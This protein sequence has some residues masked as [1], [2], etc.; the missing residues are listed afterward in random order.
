MLAG[1]A[2]VAADA[3]ADLVDPALLNFLGKKG[4]GNGG[5][6]RPDHVEHAAP[7]LADHGVRRGEPAD[8]NDRL[9]RH[10]LDEGNIGLLLPLLAEAG[11]YRVVFPVAQVDVPQVRELGEHFDDFAPLAVCSDA[12]R[13]HK[14]VNSQAHGDGT[15]VADRVLGLLEQLPKQAKPVFKRP[16]VLVV[17]L[18]AAV[19]KEMHQEGRIVA[20][21]NID[22]VGA[23]LLGA[24][25]R[26]VVPAAELPDI[27]LVHAAGLGRHA[28]DP[29]LR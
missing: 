15:A 3:F 23:G 25:R 10:L 16:A 18:V 17:P 12:L 2:D 26:F 24:Q 13:A 11:G 20:R 4:I 29:R 9:G 28:D 5:P 27:G 21:V 14:L 7:D 22:Y 8:T 1:D 19:L 6:R